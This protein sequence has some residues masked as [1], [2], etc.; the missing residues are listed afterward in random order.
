M[1]FEDFR[2]EWSEGVRG[3]SQSEREQY[4]RGHGLDPS[5]PAEELGK[6]IYAEVF[7]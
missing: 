7:G 1:S 4:V 2:E 6:K 5:A 3:R